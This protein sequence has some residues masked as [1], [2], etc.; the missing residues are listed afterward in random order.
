MTTKTKQKINEISTK[1]KTMEIR[2]ALDIAI[3]AAS[4]MKEVALES[5]DSE[6]ISNLNSAGDKLKSARPTA[7]S[8]PNAVNYIIHLAKINKNN[9]IKLS[10][11]IEKF[12]KNQ[13]NSLKKIA[14]FGSS[15]IEDNDTILTHCNSDTVVE[16]LKKAHDCG[17]KINVVC[18]ETRPRKQGYITANALSEYGIPVT[19][20]IDSAVHLIMKKLKVDKVIVGADTVCSDGDV[21]NKIGTSQIALCAKEMNIQFIVATQ[22]IKFSTES[23]SGTI[24]KIEER[25]T[26]E[27]AGA[28]ELPGVKI[29]N[30]AFDIT[31]SGYVD[32]IVTEFGVIPPQAAYGL[33]KEKFGWK[34]NRDE[35]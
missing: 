11:E 2:G 18:T 1:I 20:I 5:P 24:V 23:V 30:P 17:K 26:T 34:L 19:L 10:S 16:I 15:M 3:A 27:I 31:D 33:L 25:D 13:E 29:M 6:L 7:V 28:D 14:E 21:I 12:I 4:A 22:S 35:S 8:L 9:K 32:V